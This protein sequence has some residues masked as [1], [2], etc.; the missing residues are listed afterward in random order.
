MDRRSL[1]VTA[2]ALVFAPHAAAARLVLP[3]AAQLDAAIGEAMARKLAPGLGVAVYSRDGVYVRG[4]GVA[5]MATGEAVTPATAFY[6]ASSTKSLTALALAALHA[7]GRLDLDQP[8]AAYAPDAPLPAAVRPGEVRLRDL[9]THTGGISNDA[10]AYRLAFTGDHD[11]ATLWRLLATSEPN[12]E[13][14][15]GRFQYT[16]VGYNIAT[17]LTDRQL[18]IGWQDL[19]RREV[20]RPAGMARASA[21]MSEAKAGGWSVAKPHGLGPDGTVGRV[22]LE[23]TDRTMQSA[24]GVIMSTQDALRWLE[25]LVEGGRVDGRQVIPESVLKATLAPRAEVGLTFAEYHRNQ[26]GLGWYIGDYRG[27]PMVHDFGSFAGFR[28]HVSFMPRRRIGLAVFANDGTV[29]SPLTDVIANYVY[30]TAAGASDAVQR[31]QAGLERV[32]V[33]AKAMVQQVAGRAP[34]A[35]TLTRPRAAYA[36]VYENEA[37]GRI[38]V[39]VQDGNLHLRYGVMKAQAQAYPASDSIRVELEP[40]RGQVVAFEGGGE[41]PPALICML[42]RFRRKA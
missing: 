21:R 5:D 7:R 26:Y 33:R 19:L 17:V 12:R 35:W 42:Q 38:E 39:T 23:K 4:F 1:I 34:P 41:R 28:A 36:G 24:G 11:P 10:L 22:Y 37:W 18:G 8:L 40:G 25:L 27:E 3:F 16:N 6:I 14:P 20:F 32:A 13:A 30:D 15:L 31:Y 9:L 2:G 29:A